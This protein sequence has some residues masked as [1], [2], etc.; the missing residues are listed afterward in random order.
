MQAVRNEAR[1]T[2]TLGD[3]VFEIKDLQYDDYIEFCD[4]ARPIITAV[5]QSLELNQEN[6]QLDLQFNFGNLDF[7]Q[8]LQ[9]S[10]EELPRMAWLCCK[11]TDPKIKL[12]E[13]KRLARRPQ[14]MLEVVLA[15]V[16]HNDLVK[17]FADFFPRMASALNELVPAATEAMVPIPQTEVANADETTE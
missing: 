17:E 9:L 7:R 1:G 15:Q 2:F 11:Q 16:K 14:T 4:L 5:S 10:K 6:G 12:A 3:R 8:L 13:V